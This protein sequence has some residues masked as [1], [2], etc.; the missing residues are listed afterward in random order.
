MP[1]LLFR[2]TLIALTMALVACG[3]IG[4][5]RDE[6]K[7]W[8][9]DKLYAEA[10]EQLKGGF[11]EKSI[12]YFEKLESRYPFGTYAQRA[13]MQIAYAY[14]KQNEQAQCLAAIDRFIRLHPNHP[15]VEIGRAHV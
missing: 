13:Q 14:Y 4:E 9:A 5:K 11:Y 7:N 3:S 2:L 6:T 15:N 10:V 8:S 1:K 12:N